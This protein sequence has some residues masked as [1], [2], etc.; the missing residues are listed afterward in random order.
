MNY[1]QI[2]ARQRVN[3][4]G[5]KDVTFRL[6]FGGTRIA[7]L[8]FNYVKGESKIFDSLHHATEDELRAACGKI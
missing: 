3:L 1:L 6:D 8:T 4:D 7:R 5:L 2:N